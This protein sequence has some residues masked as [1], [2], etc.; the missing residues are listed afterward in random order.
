MKGV[1]RM[2]TVVNFRDI[3]NLETKNHT[4]VK[5]Q[6]FFRSGEIVNVHQSD[7]DRLLTDYKLKTIVD[8]RGEA[9]TKERP[10][11][12][13]EGIKYVNIDILKDAKEQGAS[14]EEL[15]NSKHTADVG[16]MR[17]YEELILTPGAKKGYQ[18]FL[19][20][21]ISEPDNPMLFHCFAGKDRTGM[22]AAL[23]L[24]ALDVPKEAILKDYLITNV[25]RR[26]ANDLIIED[27]RQKGLTE[28]QLKEVDILMSVDERYLEHSLTLMKQEYGGINEYI[29]DALN[30]PKSFFNDMKSAFTA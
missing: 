16:M 26:A 17:L 7:V 23:I 29:T 21:V 25:S 18:E 1:Y 9:E 15:V 20:L 12:S 22:G 19:E 30:M 24:S 6:H 14:M 5:S 13:I 8:F 2:K 28:A 3:G 10:D 11:D 4:K 27:L